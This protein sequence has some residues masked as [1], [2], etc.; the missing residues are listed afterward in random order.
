MIY[1]HFLQKLN[2]PREKVL[3]LL[4]GIGETG[5]FSKNMHNRKNVNALLVLGIEIFLEMEFQ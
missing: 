4:R 5:I 3:L 1:K 2:N